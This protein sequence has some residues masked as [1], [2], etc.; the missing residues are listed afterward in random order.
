MIQSS[1]SECVLDCL[2]AARAQVIIVVISG[3]ICYHHESGH[4][5]DLMIV[6]I[7]VL[8]LMVAIVM[9]MIGNIKLLQ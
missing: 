3:N 4:I 2:L 1:A 8:N 9:I 6:R 7:M 5:G